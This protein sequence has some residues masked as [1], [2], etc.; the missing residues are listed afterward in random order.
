MA[1]LIVSST[2]RNHHTIISAPMSM[3]RPNSPAFKIRKEKVI[4]AFIKAITS[5]TCMSPEML[6]FGRATVRRP[7]EK[8]GE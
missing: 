8:C 2:L 5:T 7:S 1:R 3:K 6:N 4:I